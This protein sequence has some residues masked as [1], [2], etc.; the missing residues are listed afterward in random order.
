MTLD[1]NLEALSKN[2]KFNQENFK[3]IIEKCKTFIKSERED[4]IYIENLKN[5]IIILENEKNKVIDKTKFIIE[6]LRN[7]NLTL[8]DKIERLS[9]DK[10]K[11][12][13]EKNDLMRK[14][15]DIYKKTQ[16]NYML[17]NE[18][19][20]T[21]SNLIREKNRITINKEKEIQQLWNKVKFNSKFEKDL[22]VQQ[23]ENAQLKNL[24]NEF[25]VEITRLNT[26]KLYLI[27]LNSILG[28]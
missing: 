22:S 17:K 25:K 12:D 4:R 1:E 27:N 7:D 15:E 18:I 8:I 24:I 5:E 23:K 21:K 16:E 14:T 28:K 11:V 19:E 26:V 20:K 9:K 3:N 2:E 13:K 10:E 6:D